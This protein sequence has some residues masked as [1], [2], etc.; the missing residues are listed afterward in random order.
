MPVAPFRFASKPAAGTPGY[1]VPRPPSPTPQPSPA[2]PPATVPGVGSETLMLNTSHGGVSSSFSLTP[3]GAYLVTV[4]GTWSDWNDRLNGKPEPDAM[5]P[6]TNTARKST[7]VGLDPDTEFARPSYGTGTPPQHWT[8]LEFS[9]DGQTWAHLEPEGG[10]Y[11]LPRPDHLYTYHLTGQ[12]HPLGIRVHDSPLT[13][14]YG[15]LKIV[16][17]GSGG[18]DGAGSPPPPAPPPPVP[19][20]PPPPTNGGT[21]TSYRPYIAS[22][23]LNKPLP[24]PAPIHPDSKLMIS[25]ANNWVVAGSNAAWLGPRH[26][27]HYYRGDTSKLPAT[28]IYVNWASATGYSCGAGGQHTFPCPS[29]LASEVGPTSQG[30]DSL[31]VIVDAIT[32]DVWEMYRVTPPGYPSRNVN[33]PNNRWNCLGYRH[34]PA[35][36]KAGTGYTLPSG[37]AM[38]AHLHSPGGL[39]VPEDFAD[40][41]AGS[42]PGTVIPHV[43]RMDSFCGSNGTRHPKFVQPAFSGDGR[44]A[45]GIPAGA[46]AQLDPSLDVATWPSVN[47]K[48]EPWR[49]ALKKLLRTM[50]VYG[51]MQVD[52]TSAPGAGGID[53]C[54]ETSVAKGGTTYPAGYK[55]PWEAAG[56]GW[57]I[58]DGIPADLMPHFRVID[59]TKW[60]GV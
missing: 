9:L 32:G 34:W 24:S 36:T 54:T 50:Q 41:F 1:Y 28:P 56:Y 46:R 57:G 58:G 38:A 43:L 53:C 39:L 52:S 35:D 45:E 31:V 27:F 21:V 11:S 25:S 4:Q 49:S 14:N 55:F 37:I 48:R 3:G 17:G 42:D 16:I 18:G 59:W 47:A 26:R 51:I 6:T 10:P 15:A 29:W 44:Q 7:E 22:S 8:Q 33:C 13:D 40:C 20:P 23:A 2:P 19:P 60:S 5:F 12:G 30:G